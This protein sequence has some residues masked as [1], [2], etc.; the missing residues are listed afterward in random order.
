MARMSD[1]EGWPKGAEIADLLAGAAT[2]PDFGLFGSQS[3]LFRRH[4]FVSQES[5]TSN[6]QFR[7]LVVAKL[8]TGI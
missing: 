1:I 5:G 8:F 6:K 3:Y 7:G 2:S 4:G